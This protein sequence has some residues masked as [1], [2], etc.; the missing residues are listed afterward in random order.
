M[1]QK[2]SLEK[3]IESP[4]WS[5]WVPVYGIYAVGGAVREGKP[6]LSNDPDN[7]P[8]RFYGS[9]I[10]HATAGVGTILTTAYAIATLLK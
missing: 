6:A 2:E 5:Q 4:H 10:Y 8:V 1:Q 3:R 9:A 7:H